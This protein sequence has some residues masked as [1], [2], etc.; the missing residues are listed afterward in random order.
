MRH[1]PPAFQPTAPPTV[2][3]P[4]PTTPV[5]SSKTPL[6]SCSLCCRWILERAGVARFVPLLFPLLLG[7][8]RLPWPRT[9]NPKTYLSSFVFAS[10]A[11]NT[12]PSELVWLFVTLLVLLLVGRALYVVPFALVHNFWS[13]EQLS[14]RDI[15]VVWWA[16]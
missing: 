15:V 10:A 9:I 2:P 5:F 1:A 6:L 12:Y 7:V 4:T 14:A 11:Q 16:H 13:A 8:G 3:A